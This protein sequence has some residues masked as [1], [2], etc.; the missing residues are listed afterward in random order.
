MPAARSA[1]AYEIIIIIK[2]YSFSTDSEG[3]GAR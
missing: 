1:R 3:V 2:I